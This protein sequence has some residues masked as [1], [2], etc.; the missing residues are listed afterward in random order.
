VASLDA[1]FSGGPLDGKEMKMVTWPT[2]YQYTYNRPALVKATEQG[3]LERVS[4]YKNALYEHQGGGVYIYK[5]SVD[6]DKLLT[7]ELE[8]Q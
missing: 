6:V 3:D 1:Y 4:N 5:G 2:T 8:T 7:Y